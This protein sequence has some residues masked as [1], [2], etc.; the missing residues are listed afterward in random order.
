MSLVTTTEMF[1]KALEVE[2]I[3]IKVE[4]LKDENVSS[5]LTQSEADR[6][7]AEM[8]KMYSEAG[9]GGLGMD[10]GKNSETLVLNSNNKLVKYILDNPEEDI[11]PT[12]CAQLYDLAVLANKPLTAEE[13]TRFVN[14]SN[15]I[16][17][18]LI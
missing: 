1:K 9:M 13:L 11:T 3:K 2:D 18:K 6:R 15:D 17:A 8:M 14:R 10:F 4:S 7:M 5:M 12:I 16:L